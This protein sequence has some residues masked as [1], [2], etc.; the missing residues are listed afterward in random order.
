[1][2]NKER[3][4]SHNGNTVDGIG[5]FL[6]TF[7]KWEDKFDFFVFAFLNTK[8]RAI[9]FVIV[10]NEDLR[11]RFLNQ[12]RILTG[13]KRSELTLWLMDR[14]VYDTTNLSVEGEWYMLS[15][16]SGGRM[17]DETDMDFTPF[18]NRWNSLTDSL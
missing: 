16:G 6:F 10:P 13:G 1:M 15:K 3:H 18:S 14:S 8:D 2:F 12:N 5:H 4:G 7:P 9:E 17:A 11:S